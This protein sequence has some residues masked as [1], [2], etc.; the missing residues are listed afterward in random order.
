MPYSRECDPLE[1]LIKLAAARLRE[2]KC[3]IANRLKTFPL[4]D[5]QLMGEAA[6]AGD[7]SDFSNEFLG[8]CVWLQVGAE[9]QRRMLGMRDGS[10]SGEH[11]LT[12]DVGTPTLR[13]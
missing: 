2:E 1:E 3:G 10:I 12:G 8:S 4:S 9:I 6:E 7:V 13:R 5:L 11:A